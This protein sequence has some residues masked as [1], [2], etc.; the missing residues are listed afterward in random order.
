MKSKLKKKSYHYDP[1]GNA[2]P[3]L[4]DPKRPK[5]NIQDDID[6]LV[7]ANSAVTIFAANEIEN[8]ICKNE[9]DYAIQN[10]YEFVETLYHTN[11]TKNSHST[12]TVDPLVS[13]NKIHALKPASFTAPSEKTLKD[14]EI[15]VKDEAEGES[16]SSN[17]PI[18]VYKCEICNFT[19]LQENIYTNHVKNES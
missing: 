4:I 13:R 9:P 8:L 17:S 5:K 12:I 19:T 1:Q 3:R 7:Y 16:I 2:I 6:V 10:S 14:N 18:P 15:C 11:E